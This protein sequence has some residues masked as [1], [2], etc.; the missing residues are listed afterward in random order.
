MKNQPMKISVFYCSNS[1]S[2]EEVH[3]CNA[4]IDDVQLNAISLPCSGKVNL[5]YL[6]KTI[7]TGSDGA[8]IITCKVGECKYLQGN[9]RAQKRIEAVDDL[10]EET[11]FGRGCLKHVSLEEGNKIDKMV[12]E[13]KSFTNH[14]K[15]KSHLIKENV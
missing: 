12:S 3:F 10:L 15:N 9:L 4:K 5:L 6:L 11:G 2:T 7:E 8:M 1:I 14:L 13:I